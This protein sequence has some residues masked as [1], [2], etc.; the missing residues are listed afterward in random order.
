[1]RICIVGSTGHVGYVLEDIEET[2]AHIAGVAPGSKGENVDRLYGRVRTLNPQAICFGDYRH[3]LDQLKPNVVVVACHF[4]DHA[5]VITEALHRNIHVF[6]EKP[7]A[8]TLSD[9]DNLWK[10]YS[11]VD[12]HFAAMLGIRYHPWVLT[13]WDQVRRG[14]VGEVRLVTGQKSY[15]LGRR[16]PFFHHRETYGGTIPWV[17]IHAIDWLHWFSGE[18]FVSVFA[19]HSAKYNRN[20]GDLEVTANCHFNLTNEVIASVSIDYL[21]PETAASHDDDRI[22]VVGTDG[23]LEV[24]DRG[25]YLINADHDGGQSLPFLPK[26]GIFSDFV[27]QISGEGKCLISAEDSFYATRAALLAR[28]SADEGRQIDFGEDDFHEVVNGA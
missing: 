15:K 22:R 14:A 18:S 19:S 4:G 23:V 28:L 26:R 6:A 11:R 27:A 25:V 17:G 9:L 12:V 2:E 8:V 13:A 24:R 3:M 21:R 7:I 20:H 5:S 16:E 10:T 1:M